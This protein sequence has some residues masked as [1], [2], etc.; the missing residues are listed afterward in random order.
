MSENNTYTLKVGEK[1]KVSPAFFNSSELMIYAGM[2][3]DATYSVVVTRT[4]GNNSFA[5]NLYLP[6]DKREFSTLKGRVQVEYVST[7]EIRFTYK[8]S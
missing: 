8:E 1:E 6:K 3:N 5:Y 2:I 7:E 4:L